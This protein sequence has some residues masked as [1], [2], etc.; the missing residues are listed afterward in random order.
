M[1]G[2]VVGDGGMSSYL[3]AMWECVL[4]DTPRATFAT[5]ELAIVLSHFDIGPIESITD[6]HRGSRRSP[7]VGVVSTKGKYL[8]KRRAVSR[9]APDRVVFAQ[10]VQKCLSAFEFPLPRLHA[11]RDDDST[12]LQLREH[13]YELFTFVPGHPYEKSEGETRH[14]GSTLGLFHEALHGFT[15]SKVRPEPHGNFHDANAIR[16]GI[17]NLGPKLTSHDSYSGNDIELAS[18][19]QRLLGFYDQSA[20]AAN[21]LG[22]GDLPEQVVHADWHPGNVLFRGGK[23]AAVVDYDSVRWSKQITDV[24]NGALQFSMISEG[25]V[26]KWPA[27]LDEKRFS[28]FMIGYRAAERLSRAEIQMIPHLMGEAL[29]TECV[30]PI[31]ETGSVGQWAGYRVLQTIQRKLAWI[32]ENHARLCELAGQARDQ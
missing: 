26:T 5:E 18:L 29:L 7:K 13:I 32:A 3:S 2:Q 22:F 16:T 11:T 28:Q 23:V 30:P 14:A 6:F 17:C 27:A 15:P 31:T 21:E 4:A 8:L 12:Y 24:A 25:D 10:R 1:I 19:L 9:A 20:K